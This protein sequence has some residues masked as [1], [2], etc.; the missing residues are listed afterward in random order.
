M[1]NRCTPEVYH[2]SAAKYGSKSEHSKGRGYNTYDYNGLG[3]IGI[4]NLHCST[5]VDL[6]HCMHN[7]MEMIDEALK[8]NVFLTKNDSIK[9]N[10]YICCLMRERD[11][12]NCLDCAV[13]L[14]TDMCFKQIKLDVAFNFVV[15]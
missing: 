7:V 1:Y 3:I 5:P 10:K 4:N 12:H 13:D 9:F 2:L 14:K 8:Y 15:K 11:D 6:Y